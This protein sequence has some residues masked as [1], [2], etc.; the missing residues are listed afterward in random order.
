MRGIGSR[1][2]VAIDGFGV[3]RGRDAEGELGS[4]RAAGIV[5]VA[6]DRWS[7]ERHGGGHG[8]I[9]LPFP[10]QKQLARISQGSHSV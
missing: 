9:V 3:G 10:G 7:K 4:S 1:S 6:G 8:E 5:A 2:T